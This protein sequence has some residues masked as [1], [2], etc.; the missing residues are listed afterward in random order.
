MRWWIL[1]FVFVGVPFAVLYWLTLK[2]IGWRDF[3]KEEVSI[4]ETTGTCFVC[5]FITVVALALVAVC[6]Y[7]I[8]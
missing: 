4:N 7:A 2:V 5:G 8:Q 6:F 1:L 3:D